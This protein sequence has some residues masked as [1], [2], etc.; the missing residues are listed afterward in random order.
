MRAEKCGGPHAG[1]RVSIQTRSR[2]TEPGHA[3]L[4]RATAHADTLGARRSPRWVEPPV[5]S[6]VVALG[7][8]L[9]VSCMLAP[10]TKRTTDA[11]VEGVVISAWRRQPR[12][13]DLYH[14]AGSD[15]VWIL[16]RDGILTASSISRPLEDNF[17]LE[18]IP[19]GDIRIA[20]ANERGAILLEHENGRVQ[21]GWRVLRNAEGSLRAGPPVPVTAPA[22]WFRSPTA[23]HTSILDVVYAQV[24]RVGIDGNAALCTVPAPDTWD[25]I[26]EADEWLYVSAAGSNRVF[27]CHAEHPPVEFNLGDDHCPCTVASDPRNPARGWLISHSSTA[28]E[29]VLR[30]LSADTIE[31]GGMVMSHDRLTVPATS[32]VFPTDGGLMALH[33]DGILEITRRGQ[34]ASVSRTWTLS[35]STDELDRAA[36]LSPRWLLAGIAD[37]DGNVPLVQ[38][39]NSVINAV[40]Y[41][42]NPGVHGE[43]SEIISSMNRLWFLWRTEDGRCL[44]GSH[45]VDFVAHMPLRRRCRRLLRQGR[46]VWGAEDGDV[47]V[48]NLASDGPAQAKVKWLDGT[49]L[50]SKA[51]RDAGSV[52]LSR[53]GR[54]L[55]AA[56]PPSNHH[57]VLAVELGRYSRL[58]FAG[59]SSYLNWSD[60]DEL[61]VQG[62]LPIEAR[63][64]GAGIIVGVEIQ[65]AF[66]DGGFRCVVREDETC[67]MTSI[68][69]RT[70]ALVRVA[71][72]TASYEDDLGSSLSIVDDTVAVHEAPWWP[73]LRRSAAEVLST[74]V[75]GLF[76]YPLLWLV[77]PS[78]MVRVVV[79]I[80]RGEQVMGK[81]YPGGRPAFRLLFGTVDYITLAPFMVRFPHIST[82]WA[83]ERGYTEAV[84]SAFGELFGL[85]INT[86]DG[87][88]ASAALHGAV[89]DSQPLQRLWAQQLLAQGAREFW[90]AQWSGRRQKHAYIA[91]PSVTVW[92]VDERG[93]ATLR[94]TSLEAIRTRRGTRW[95]VAPSRCGKSTLV[96]SLCEQLIRDEA[97]VPILVGPDILSI[98]QAL[99]SALLRACNVSLPLPLV[100]ALL[101][102]GA[103]VPVIDEMSATHASIRQQFSRNDLGM[104]IA[105]CQ[106]IHDVPPFGVVVAPAPVPDLLQHLLPE[107]Q[108]MLLDAQLS[109]KALIGGLDRVW[110]AWLT[111]HVSAHFLGRGIVAQRPLW[112]PLQVLSRD[113]GASGRTDA[114]SSFEHDTIYRMTR[115]IL[116]I[117]GVGGCG[118]STLAFAFV[119]ALLDAATRI[120][121]LVTASDF[122]G[123]EATACRALREACG[124]DIPA[125]VVR[126]LLETGA[127]VVVVDAY[128]EMSGQM[129]ER[130]TAEL[131]ALRDTGEPMVRS[132]VITTRQPVRVF[133]R[134]VHTLCPLPLNSERL[135]RFVAE[136]LLARTSRDASLRVPKLSDQLQIFSVL[137]DACRGRMIADE[138]VAIPAMF[139]VRLVDTA[140]EAV[141]KSEPLDEL[142]RYFPELMLGYAAS[143]IESN[144]VRGEGES[145]RRM[146]CLSTVALATLGPD[147]VPGQLDWADFARIIDAEIGTSKASQFVEDL[148]GS[149]LL[150]VRRDSVRFSL[151]PLAEYLGAFCLAERWGRG[152]VDQPEWVGVLGA[153]ERARDGGRNN[154]GFALALADVLRW[155]RRDSM[156]SATDELVRCLLEPEAS[157]SLKGQHFERP[158]TCASAESVKIAFFNADIDLEQPILAAIELRELGAA[159]E[160]AVAAGRDVSLSQHHAVRTKDIVKALRMG[161][162]VVHFSGHGLAG[163]RL[164]VLDA[165]EVPTYLSPVRLASLFVAAGSEGAAV[166]PLLVVLNACYSLGA[167]ESLLDHA[168]VVIGVD[169]EIGHGAA[170]SFS[171]CFYEL[172]LAGERLGSAFR[173]ARAT[174]L[175][176]HPLE[177]PMVL[178]YR[179]EVNSITLYDRGFYVS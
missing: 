22:P 87:L 35:S 104:A 134:S 18:S 23:R 112:T 95:I 154:A 150:Q 115:D 155:R 21:G 89:E 145:S 170:E 34:R 117:S 169:D 98:E 37:S 44:A 142:P 7:S 14:T 167:A 66:E 116:S 157:A 82:L 136:H 144:V 75:F 171:T 13:L 31:G 6:H 77:W 11:V 86:R 148:V 68:D 61:R 90:R 177:P 28:D 27:A 130:L 153:L 109:Q 120:P 174:A 2:D 141:A 56:Y 102:G 152:A 58:C 50:L 79:S 92:E 70:E 137:A 36:T 107:S 119:R 65:V 176:E 131:C 123:F 46:A 139:V 49:A 41:T 20:V 146:R 30:P 106:D 83:L 55:T 16:T 4:L 25:T 26:S 163:G 124:F 158:Q 52:L 168:R 12:V 103:L 172:L 175:A 133:G 110:I 45:D 71:H 94:S 69:L 33:S 126:L 178:V 67:R 42:L 179:G 48:W 72:V 149:G 39:N 156:E 32:R 127:I 9:L 165:R 53:E 47:E 78:G 96:S 63:W 129:R 101:R 38:L 97:A 73:A 17:A 151:D 100:S 159:V 121:V 88:L 166:C 143:Q 40:P 64:R 132:V 138:D 1:R 105:A 125:A 93:T 162:T 15:I 24:V 161:P 85:S 135:M 111:P 43:R 74:L 59:C 62:G 76:L 60:L 164:R 108:A 113:A 57:G 5:I 84:A 173:Q 80:G 51:G 3:T 91:A 147:Y 10:A 160:S 128:S 81:R 118:K 54:L 29:L 99:R 19:R 8:L 122:D 140:L 114:M